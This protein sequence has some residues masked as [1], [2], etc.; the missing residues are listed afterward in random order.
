MS[1]ITGMLQRDGRPLDRA[2][3]ARM[4]ETLATWG[5][6]AC[7]IW[8]SGPVGLGQLT[9]ATTP[10][11]RAERLPYA[12][13]DAPRVLVADARIDNR[14]ELIAALSLDSSDRTHLG[15]GELILRAYQRWGHASPEHLVGDFAFAIW[16]GETQELFCARDALGVRPFYY[17][18]SDRLF[19]FAT[20]IGALLALPAVPRRLNEE[21]LADYL[22]L[23]PPD[24]TKTF[25]RDI[26]KLPPG[27]TLCVSGGGVTRR[28]Y[29]KLDPSRELRLGSDAEYAEAFRDLFTD[30]VRCRLRSS[31]PVAAML[32]GG[33]DSSSIVCTAR[34]LLEPGQ[35]II[36]LSGVF[37]SFRSP[38]FRV[39]EASYIDLVVAGGGVDAR[40]VRAD[41]ASP[42]FDFLWRGEEPIPA[43]A[44]YM[45]WS[46][47]KA[48]KEQGLRVLLSGNDGDSVV[49]YGHAYLAE[50]AWGGKW[51]AL[52]DELY[53][54]S[55]RV[56]IGRR[57]IMRRYVLSTL[58][59]FTLMS[60]WQRL[61]RNGAP[62][63][64]RRSVIRPEFADRTGVRDRARRFLWDER[65]ARV[66][67]RAHHDSVESSLLTLLLEL[68]AR[69]AGA[70]GLEPRYPFFDRRLV[71]FCL[72]LPG[73]QKLHQGWN[74]VVMRRAMTGIV[75]AEIQWRRNKQNL[76]PNFNIR[77]LD[78]R[79]LLDDVVLRAPRLIEEYVDVV[80]LREA[81]RRYLE[82]PE[83]R[84][85]D[86]FTVFWAV[87]IALWL[88]ESGLA[89]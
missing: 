61:R 1:A 76:S 49:G 21:V 23:L 41:D 86:S 72:A 9:L 46:I 43:A 36:T 16:D 57:D 71:E 34:R 11:S 83:R 3:L 79:N 60:A 77:L 7:G 80:G 8:N 89:P 33:L 65:P 51:K 27:H 74:R 67:R 28:C 62:I 75:P 48:A 56:G 64:D 12:E 20:Q 22:A 15:D 63:Y 32:S 82:Q 88:R 85:R 58:V 47:F 4:V 18:L 13:G 68:F 81:Y 53:E 73:H 44:L 54:L 70:F 84:T 38:K 19:I 30:A 35:R 26:F 37:P 25:Y 87:T 69:G 66:D 40:Y 17:H 52:L 31:G 55:R 24:R 5:P 39:D 59:P 2:D 50:L 6:D 10:E 42:L 29:W 78:N 14:D 45:D